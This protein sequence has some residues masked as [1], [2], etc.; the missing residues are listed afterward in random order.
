MSKRSPP[1]CGLLFA[2]TG[3]STAHSPRRDAA[4]PPE[5]DKFLVL[6]AVVASQSPGRS[7]VAS[8]PAAGCLTP[9]NPCVCLASRTAPYTF[10]GVS[11]DDLVRG[12]AGVSGRLR[13]FSLRE[14]AGKTYRVP[15]RVL[16][17]KVIGL[18][19]SRIRC[20]RDPR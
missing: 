4:F 17:H 8:E 2:S 9:C 11:R 5:D 7:Q 15:Y 6:P 16:V 19:R 3:N 18:D 10:P 13:Q 14:L 12:R 20:N 1:A